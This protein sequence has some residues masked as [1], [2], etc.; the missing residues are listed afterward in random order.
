MNINLKIY[1]FAWL[2][3]TAMPSFAQRESG[4]LMQMTGTSTMQIPGMGAMPPHTFT[5]QK[6]VPTK[7]PKQPDP[8]GIFPHC[9][10][11]N[12]KR[13]GDD[14]S[15]HVSC[16]GPPSISGDGHF[17]WSGDS[18]HGQAHMTGT[19]Q[20]QPISADQTLNGQRI[21]SCAYTPHGD[22]Q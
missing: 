11:S 10:V 8:R 13:V 3:L 18:F 21:G 5:Y 6:C 16:P 9:T 20:G 14:I 22:G 12:F 2:M 1:G 7:K 17:T 19:I 4:D 15:G